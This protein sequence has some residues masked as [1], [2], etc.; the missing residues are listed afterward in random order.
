MR[1][2]VPRPRPLT[3]REVWRIGDW[4]GASN[5]IGRRWEAVAAS[6]VAGLLDRP[7]PTYP[8]LVPTRC[9]SFVLDAGHEQA[10]Q[11]AGYA[12]PDALLVGPVED[13]LGLQSIDFK[14]SIEVADISQVET[15]ALERLLD[16][17]ELPVVEAK[18]AAFAPQ[19]PPARDA[20]T[21]IDGFFVAPDHPAN[22]AFLQSQRN[23]RAERPLTQDC[24]VLLPVNGREFFS[25]LAGWEM[26]E[27]L[28]QQEG[29]PRALN[30]LEGAEHYYRL[31][32][33]TAGALASRRRSVFSATTP[34]LDPIA[35]LAQLRRTLRLAKLTDVIGYLDRALAARHELRKLAAGI[36]RA[37]YPF[38]AFH[39]DLLSR[40]VTLPPRNSPEANGADRLWGRLYS[41]VQQAIAPGIREQ[42]LALVRAGKTDAEAIAALQA[43]AAEHGQTARAHAL[44]LIESQLREA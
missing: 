25:P 44:E 38:S 18:R 40:G 4:G 3:G 2:A 13:R 41:A 19:P 28:A 12:H 36:G 39:Q 22:H 8:A 11:S 30:T 34:Q 43:R 21:L 5:L 7:S 20:L 23:A 17:E 9:V 37:A 33:G 42:G 26:A 27:H 16:A 10:L 32:A 6:M 24:V 29:A 15:D 1:H 35:E 14:W 31:G